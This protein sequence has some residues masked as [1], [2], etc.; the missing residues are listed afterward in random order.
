MNDENS[1][2]V[3]HNR[4][5]TTEGKLTMVKKTPATEGM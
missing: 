2:E 3:S 5:A 1:R 4:D